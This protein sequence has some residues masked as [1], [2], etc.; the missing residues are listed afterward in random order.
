MRSKRALGEICVAG[1]LV[2]NTHKAYAR[3]QHAYVGK[4]RAVNDRKPHPWL[5]PTNPPCDISKTLLT[6]ADDNCDGGKL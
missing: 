1:C 5:M 3:D 2:A 4:G 6:N